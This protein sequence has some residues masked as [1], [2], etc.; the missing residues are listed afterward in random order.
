[1]F[2]QLVLR[3][4]VFKTLLNFDLGDNEKKVSKHCLRIT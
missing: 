2:A 4:S 1:M 3:R